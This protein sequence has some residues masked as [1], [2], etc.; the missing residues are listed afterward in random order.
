M[1]TLMKFITSP[2]LWTSVIIVIIFLVFWNINSRVYRRYTR[3][4]DV[5][6][7][8]SGKRSSLIR[9]SYTAVRYILLILLVLFLL[10]VNGFNVTTM[11]A[12]LGIA[13]AVI[14]L[15]IQDPLKD[16]VTGIS[17]MTDH[18]FKVGDVV[19][20]HN[21]EGI[22]IFFDIKV[23]KI[24][25]LSDGTVLT[26]ANRNISEIELVSDRV[27]IDVPLPYELKAA[28]A[29]EVMGKIASLAAEAGGISSC[30]FKGTQ[31]FA[32]SAILYRLSFTCD[33]RKRM[34]SRRTVNRIIQNVL[35]EENI[36][37]PYMQIDVHTD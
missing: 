22:I 19:R 29:R 37:I 21:M 15:A 24:E 18:F 31:E 2:R 1:E 28:R 26:I 10:Q 30:E 33:R 13:S 9:L 32:D 36:S 25:S 35:E 12:G 27:N 17:I 16:A 5:I 8:T 11:V 6:T 3:S 20:Y 23:T 7:L 14:G 4:T 34:D